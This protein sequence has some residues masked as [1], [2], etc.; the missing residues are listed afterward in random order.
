MAIGAK[1]IDALGGSVVKIG[2]DLIDKLHTSDE[3]KQ[4]LKLQV[5]ELEQRGELAELNADLA[6]RLA[7]I[8]VNKAEATNASV[9]VSGWRP[10]VG[11]VSV[12]GLAYQF[13]GQPLITF[14]AAMFNRPPAPQIDVMDLLMLLGGMLGLSGMRTSEKIK[15]VSRS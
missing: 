11:W 2:A 7:Q 5:M 3:E 8:E 12:F 4:K 10:A 6:V 13:L 1:I 9:F 15:G 14:I